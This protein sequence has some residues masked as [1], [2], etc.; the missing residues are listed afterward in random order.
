MSIKLRFA[1]IFSGFVAIM[2]AV[3]SISIYVLYSNFRET[4]FYNRV[5]SEGNIFHN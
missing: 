1:L 4:E 5:K 3:S 2:L